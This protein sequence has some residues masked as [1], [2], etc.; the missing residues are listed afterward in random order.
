MVGLVASVFK[1]YLT[2][3]IDSSYTALRPPDEYTSLYFLYSK[4]YKGENVFVEER[5]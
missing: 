2:V 4:Q 5:Y 3:D 1:L